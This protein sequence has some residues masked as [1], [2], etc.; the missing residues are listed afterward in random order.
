MPSGQARQSEFVVQESLR[1][2][3]NVNA[4]RRGSAGGLTIFAR[5]R[6]N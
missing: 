4:P 2:P 6:K 1:K 3:R 5:M